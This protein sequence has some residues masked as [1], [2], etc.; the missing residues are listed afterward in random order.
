LAKWWIFRN[1]SRLFN[2]L[3]LTCEEF[4]PKSQLWMFTPSFLYGIWMNQCF[5]IYVEY[6]SN[7]WCYFCH[8]FL[9][10][11]GILSFLTRSVLERVS[12]SFCCWTR[13]ESN[14]TKL[15]YNVNTIILNSKLLEC[16]NELI[17]FQFLQLQQRRKN[18]CLD[19]FSFLYPVLLFQFWKKYR[20]DT[21]NG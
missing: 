17:V 10:I 13:V 9:K 2:S 18:F 1:S 19:L 14:G 8:F 16:E 7:I 5:C 21:G 12:Y 3:C 6:L 15:N 4:S 20:Q 11:L